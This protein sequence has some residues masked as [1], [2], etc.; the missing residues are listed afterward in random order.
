M[1][2]IKVDKTR[3]ERFSFKPV[4][5]LKASIKKKPELSLRLK[6]DFGAT[7]EAQGV[8]VDDEFKQSLRE[9]WRS[10]IKEDVRRVTEE[11]GGEDWYLKRVLRGE[12]I[13]VHV[14]VGPEG[15]SKSLREGNDK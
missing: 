15:H 8:K 10:Q 1:K 7:L 3:L 6:E 14:K 5:D 9:S 2:R 12:P 11:R 13:R 4:K